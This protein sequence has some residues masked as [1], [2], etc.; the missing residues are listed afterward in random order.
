MVFCELPGAKS[1][2]QKIS[3]DSL[4]RNGKVNIL[5]LGLHGMTHGFLPRLCTKEL[6]YVIF[7]LHKKLWI[8]KLRQLIFKAGHSSWKDCQILF[9]FLLPESQ[10]LCIAGIVLPLP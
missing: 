1:H 8:T 7:I 4:K 9:N 10:G 2:G 6:T 3:D 5:G